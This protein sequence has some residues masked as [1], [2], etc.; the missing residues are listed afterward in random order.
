MA[1]VR[2]TRGQCS[3]LPGLGCIV[4]IKGHIKGG[5]HSNA[6]SGFDFT[7]IA[8]LAHRGVY[9]LN[10]AK[11]PLLATIRGAQ[12]IALPHDLNF[13]L[14]HNFMQLTGVGG[15][16]LF[17]FGQPIKQRINTGASRL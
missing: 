7:C 4:G 6:V 1:S 17:R 13:E 5:Q 2:I 16:G 14:L 9:L 12:E 15:A 8:N 10:R 11:Q 3:V